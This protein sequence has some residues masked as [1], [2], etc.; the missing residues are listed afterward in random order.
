MAEISQEGGLFKSD[1]GS[2]EPGS[3]SK[4]AVRRQRVVKP[5]ISRPWGP[6]LGAP[7]KSP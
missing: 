2:S 1:E 4:G 7:A 3:S 6:V 5:P